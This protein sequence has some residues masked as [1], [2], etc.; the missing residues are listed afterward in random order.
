MRASSKWAGTDR[1]ADLG[2]VVS[3]SARSRIERLIGAG[4]EEGAKLLLDGRGHSV[5][6]APEG[7]F[8]GPTVFDGVTAGMSIYR[9]E[10]FGPVL[11]M[12]GVD[13]LDAAIDLI[14]ANPNGN[15]VALFTQDGGAARQFQN[16][17]DVGGRHQPADSR[18]GGMVQL[19]G[20]ARIETGRPR[21]QR[22][23]GDPVLDADQDGDGTLA[24]ARHGAGRREY[25]H[26][27]EVMP[28]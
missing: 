11:C 24:G 12:T 6:Q 3:K 25:D 9:E 8:I 26:H 18:A 15:G 14:N 19:Y 16:E 21:P 4:V 22:Q 2:P 13:T 10:I 23:A 28:A 17:I 1:S 20:L 7:N 5:A 27:A